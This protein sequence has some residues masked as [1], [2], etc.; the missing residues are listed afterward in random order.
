MTGIAPM[1][2]PHIARVYAATAFRVHVG[3]NLG[4]PI[5]APEC[6]EPGDIYRLA[7]DAVALQLA[8][9][10]TAGENG[11][12]R[13][14]V[15]SELGSPGDPV[16][17][18]ARVMLMAED[19]DTVQVLVLRHMPSAQEM[20]L[21]LSPLVARLDYTLIEIAQDVSDLPV[22]D[23][24]CAAFAA[25]TRITL[26]DG[27]QIPVERLSVGNTVLTRD[28]GAQAIRWIGKVTLRAAGPFAPVVIPSEHL[29]NLGDLVVSPFHRIFLYQRGPDRVGGC[30]EVLV[31]ARHLVDD[32]RIRRREGGYVDYYSLIFDRHEIVYA[33][34]IPVESQMISETTMSRLPPDLAAEIRK[35]FPGLSHKASFATEIGREELDRALHRALGDIAT[36]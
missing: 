7:R 21:P 12:Q 34:G 2:P 20:I 16:R 29:G 19:G 4:D 30:A 31:Q 36:H 3:A 5:G 15:G 17:L 24:A 10:P 11:D 18:L 13:I 14:T 25:G 27:A 28:H 32:D 9:N 1:T 26:P 33:E 22:T 23:I 6:C 8:L 35:R